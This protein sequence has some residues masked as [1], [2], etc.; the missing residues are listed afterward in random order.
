MTDTLTPPEPPKPLTEAAWK[1][2]PWEKH[3]DE[4]DHDYALFCRWLVTRD[5]ST[6]RRST[7]PGVV[8]RLMADM[9]WVDRATAY[10]QA[11]AVELRAAVERTLHVSVRS[12]ESSARLGV[13]WLGLA[14]QALQA[15]PDDA[16]VLVNGERLR[17]TAKDV[18][19]A[20]KQAVELM[21]LLAGESTTTVAL[22]APAGGAG[23]AQGGEIVDVGSLPDDL[24]LRLAEGLDQ[25]DDSE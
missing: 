16:P 24:L 7:D 19:Q 22:Q 14:L 12:L 5:Y 21:R 15:T 17:L 1:R 2:T 25:E 4:T 8:R 23:G 6:V 13:E 9:S 20:Q 10:D 18:L 3:P 11:Q